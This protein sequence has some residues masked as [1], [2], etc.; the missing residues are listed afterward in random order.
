[1]AP[2]EP[3]SSQTGTVE[4]PANARRAGGTDAPSYEESHY[5]PR[6]PEEVGQR[7]PRIV[8][9]AAAPD[10]TPDQ[11]AIFD[12]RYIEPADALRVQRNVDYHETN[13]MR[14]V[15]EEKGLPNREIDKQLAQRYYDRSYR[16]S[17][18]IVDS[19][20]PGLRDAGIP[21]ESYYMKY[22]V[23]LDPANRQNLIEHA[24]FG[25][26]S[27][28]AAIRFFR[29]GTSSGAIPPNVAFADTLQELRDRYVAQRGGV[30]PAREATDAIPPT[31]EVLA[32]ISS[33]PVMPPPVAAA[34]APV[35]TPPVPDE[36]P[37][38]ASLI[39]DAEG[40]K[41]VP[42]TEGRGWRVAR[43]QDDEVVSDAF[44]TK[45][46][47]ERASNRMTK[48]RAAQPAATPPIESVTPVAPVPETVR[49][50]DGDQNLLPGTKEARKPVFERQEG[51]IVAP[52]P[53]TLPSTEGFLRNPVEPTPAAE[54]EMQRINGQKDL[55]GAPDPDP[56]EAPP[57]RNP[58][59]PD[60][61][62]T[63]VL[64]DPAEVA[65]A[66]APPPRTKEAATEPT[67]GAPDV[68]GLMRLKADEVVLDP[69]NFQPRSQRTNTSGI[70][71]KTIQDI[72]DNFDP[73]QWK[74]PVLVWKRPE[75]SKW[76]VTSGHH[77][78]EAARRMDIPFYAMEVEGDLA[79]AKRI[80]RR[81]NSRNIMKP[82]A[83]GRAIKTEIEEEGK[84]LAEAS[85]I[86][87]VKGSDARRYLQ[88]TE[89]PEDLQI[90]VDSGQIDVNI[91]A[92]FGKAIED[93]LLSPAAAQSM[94]VNQFLK[95]DWSITSLDDVL[96]AA[97]RRKA[98]MGT[99]TTQGGMFDGLDLGAPEA[100]VVFENLQALGVA[101]RNEQAQ[102]KAL[103]VVMADPGRTK[104]FQREAEKALLAAEKKINSLQT[105][106]GM[107]AKRPKPGATYSTIFPGIPQLAEVAERAG[108]KAYDVLSAPSDVAPT[109]NPTRP[110]GRPDL[111][112]GDEAF[113]TEDI[114]DVDKRVASTNPT[115]IS[116][117]Q[118][119]E[120][121]RWPGEAGNPPTGA[122]IPTKSPYE[123]LWQKAKA[124]ATVEDGIKVFEDAA[125][126]KYG[127]RATNRHVPTK[128]DRSTG[129][130]ADPDG[131]T[132][133]KD[134]GGNEWKRTDQEIERFQTAWNKVRTMPADGRVTL[135][136]Q[137]E[138]SANKVFTGGYD[139]EM[140]GRTWGEHAARLFQEHGDMQVV[141]DKFIDD[142]A[143]DTGQAI[144]DQESTKIGRGWDL[145]GG[146]MRERIRYAPENAIRTFALDF[147]GDVS[148]MVQTGNA[149][150]LRMA[151]DP[152][153]FRE[154]WRNVKKGTSGLDGI[155]DGPV[156]DLTDGF[157]MTSGYQPELSRASPRDDL[158]PNARLGQGPTRV[159][160]SAIEKKLL[161]GAPVLSKGV[162]PLLTSQIGRELNNAREQAFRQALW[163][164][165][166]LK[167]YPD[168]LREFRGTAKTR[169][170]RWN[171]ADDVVKQVDQAIYDLAVEP[172][173][174][175]GIRGKNIVPKGATRPFSPA[176]VRQ[177]ATDVLTRNGVTGD[178]LT[179]YPD[180][181]ARDWTDRVR[182]MS[183]DGVD[184]ANKALFSYRETNLDAKLRRV[185]FFHYWA[186]RAAPLYIETAMRHPGLLNAY[187]NA[188]DSMEEDGMP[189]NMKW[190]IPLAGSAF[191][192]AAFVN[193]VGLFQTAATFRQQDFDPENESGLFRVLRKSGLFMHPILGFIGDQAGYAGEGF[194]I[195][196]SMTA[197]TRRVVEA[198]NNVGRSQGIWGDATLAPRPFE[199][200]LRGLRGTV[201]GRL[202]GSTN[203]PATSSTATAE[204]TINDLI[205]EDAEETYGPREAWPS[206]TWT[207]VTD[208]QNDPESPEYVAAFQRYSIAEAAKTGIRS[209]SPLPVQVRSIA[210]DERIAAG[211]AARDV[212][213]N[214]PGNSRVAQS[215]YPE[216]PFIASDP[217][218]DGT[219]TA[220]EVKWMQ[221]W[222]RITGKRYK[223]GDLERTTESAR[224]STAVA[225]AGS[226][227]ARTLIVESDQFYD[228]G[229]DRGRFAADRWGAIA[230]G[231]P[232]GRTL[233]GGQEYTPQSL[234]LLSREER[235]LLA[236]Q[237]VQEH[238]MA[239]EL[240]DTRAKRDTYV[241]THPTIGRF[242][243]WKTDVRKQ[244]GDDLA[245]YRAMVS[246]GNP[247]A[248]RYF[249]GLDDSDRSDEEVDR[250]TVG[251]AAF[252]AVEGERKSLYDDNPISVNDPEGVPYT[253]LASAGS[254][255]G[256]SGGPKKDEAARIAES[257]ATYER[258]LV[259]Y[260]AYLADMGITGGLQNLN[261]MA[262][263]AVTQNIR[264]AGGPSAPSKPGN[265]E[266]YERWAAAQPEGKDSSVGA[267]V[268]AKTAN[269]LID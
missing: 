143:K 186:S 43:T 83:Y 180:R 254:D 85:A 246:Q 124:A 136:A 66:A 222:K 259:E 104:A 155:S 140:E 110:G 135:S 40:F 2:G 13:R 16:E 47:A 130:L 5:R 202:P 126:A 82:S 105:D 39:A 120:P 50:P 35:D 178:A 198:I 216:L 189:D 31:P 217:F 199:D 266:A 49:T 19:A 201:S 185:V 250:D 69:K 91:G 29:N 61:P 263:S 156:R 207:R 251:T 125:I 134:R 108:R 213:Y 32:D 97:A 57:L 238:G 241:E 267:Y 87:K 86:H 48:E 62:V 144:T 195:D 30:T 163:M 268:A 172:V 24:I 12:A 236:D 65:K 228:L 237:W 127:P 46:K 220:E 171:I 112:P 232:G 165:D 132:Y 151:L 182:T 10:V 103:K 257:M 162:A 229:T 261:P 206:G 153:L 150:S 197:S 34:P 107:K 11:R 122:T 55:F 219:I 174:I 23:A 243:A 141:Q 114:F 175:R 193:P 78:H 239:T 152:K 90:L 256:G 68:P 265:V 99:Q 71:E 235:M 204:S 37:D 93:G 51:G 1:M 81:G 167:K 200:A 94:Y 96:V 101:L 111:D 226:D 214:A 176:D 194:P 42:N 8:D 64:D 210:R 221:E 67:P 22:G 191:G 164:G 224:M 88:V 230:F 173:T 269:P 148:Q 72:I 205:M 245:G 187:F 102:R 146:L 234:R 121:M 253:G 244:Y 262:R 218:A 154:M 14:R 129:K 28:D 188:V 138:A 131:L 247:N 56:V 123:P 76:V 79:A 196:P 73:N 45:R 252:L 36:A 209:V 63:S 145:V 44:D 258:K 158:G 9:R 255:G 53:S 80:G 168:V 157:G 113:P 20:M 139:P 227:T 95:K 133:N 192:Y 160:A 3:P 106:L 41:L 161:G 100:D 166:I 249:E 98:S 137:S 117:S 18:L 38:Y 184:A 179:W 242:D 7:T 118:G 212:P 58:V 89:L 183:D 170:S 52:E 181:L 142:L 115:T 77:R 190:F 26:A 92:R 17:E 225:S 6:T 119:P 215:Q 264:N 54:R 74:E 59:Q 223:E 211:A 109:V 147:L 177:A 248:A 233:I 33:D 60:Q 169:A 231:E 159:V 15:L 27:S 208:A 84:T 25:N 75:D 260:N 149:S 21:V 4:R 203:I 116:F 240:A 128:I 70:D